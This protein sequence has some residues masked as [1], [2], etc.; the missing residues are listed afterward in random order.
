MVWLV[1]RKCKSFIK[2]TPV[3]AIFLLQ[4]SLALDMTDSTDWYGLLRN[5]VNAKF[6]FIKITIIKLSLRGVYS[7]S[8]QMSK[9]FQL[10]TCNLP[11]LHS[12]NSTLS[13][14]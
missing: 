2:L 11:H 4:F 13:I 7:T 10:A 5:D 6:A 1:E 3:F 8:T 12:V 14:V 9:S